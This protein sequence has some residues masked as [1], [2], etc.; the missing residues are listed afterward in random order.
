MSVTPERP[1]LA[2][3]EKRKTRLVAWVKSHAGKHLTDFDLGELE[4]LDARVNDFVI[5]VTGGTL[6]EALCA[7]LAPYS[8]V[9]PLQVVDP[10]YGQISLRFF[11]QS[12]LPSVTARGHSLL[13]E[14]P[15][16]FIPS[17]GGHLQ[18]WEAQLQAVSRRVEGRLRAAEEASASAPRPATG[19]G[20]VAP[21]P[22]TFMSAADL[23]GYLGQ[24]LPKVESHLRRYRQSH[25]DCAIEQKDPRHN[26][27]RILYRVADV[28]LPLMEKLPLWRGAPATDERRTDE[29]SQG[30]D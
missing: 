27:P 3:W 10:C 15:G 22:A 6:K 30:T 7:M 26:E 25:P 18:F 13:P 28:W 14:Y 1:T 29:N 20:E 16:R 8:Y 4:E 19:R 5:A 2:E 9:Q 17:G 21:P 12:L 23:A 24:P 11:G